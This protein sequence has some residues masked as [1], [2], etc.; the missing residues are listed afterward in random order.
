MG[1]E[2]CGTKKSGSAGGR[3]ACRFVCCRTGT[4]G[5]SFLCFPGAAPEEMDFGAAFGP[6]FVSPRWCGPRCGRC[7]MLLCSPRRS[8]S[9]LPSAFPPRGPA[10]LALAVERDG[11]LLLPDAS[12]LL[13][14]KKEDRRRIFSFARTFCA[15]ALIFV[16]VPAVHPRAD[17]AG[18]R[19]LPI[20][21]AEKINL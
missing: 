1:K 19:S 21:K 7:K 16:L 14:G 11:L 17:A 4:C 2:R 6:A 20:D 9:L 15:L 3:R 8:L 5:G 13:G 10:V 12:P 18:R